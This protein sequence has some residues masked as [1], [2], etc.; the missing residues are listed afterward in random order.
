MKRSLIVVAIFSGVAILSFWQ[1][2]RS[3]RLAE[4]RDERRAAMLVESAAIDLVPDECSD[5]CPL[6]AARGNVMRAGNVVICKHSNQPFVWSTVTPNGDGIPIWRTD[7][8]ARFYAYSSG[9]G[10]D[11]RRWFIFQLPDGPQL[12]SDSKINWKEQVC[13]D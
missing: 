8:V 10:A 1:L 5:S 9:R 7:R 13:I 11:G 2:R 12:L 4:L 6:K 3:A